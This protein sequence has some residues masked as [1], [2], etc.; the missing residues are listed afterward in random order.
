[1]DGIQILIHQES[2]EFLFN[3]LSPFTGFSKSR[4]RAKSFFCA[5]LNNDDTVTVRASD[6]Q[7]FKLSHDGLVVGSMLVSS[8]GDVAPTSA[9]HLY[10]LICQNLN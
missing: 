5:V 8:V 4:W 9:E 2:F 10:Q 6:G 7:D 3:D 1:M